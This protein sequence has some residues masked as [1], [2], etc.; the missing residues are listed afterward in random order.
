MEILVSGHTKLFLLNKPIFSNTGKYFFLVAATCNYSNFD[1][2]TDQSSGELLMLM[3]D[4]GAI[5]V[6]SALRA[7]YAD[8]NYA[9]NVD[10]YKY[11]IDT[12]RYGNVKR[13][14]LGDI[15]YKTKQRIHDLINDRKYFLIG[16]PSME[17]QFPKLVAS[18]DS[19]NH[20][21]NTQPIQLQALSQTE[22]V[23]TVRDTGL[24]QPQQISGR[25]NLA[26]YDADRTNT[27][28]APELGSGYKY[29]S[30]GSILFRG[31]D[32]IVNGNMKGEFIV[33]KDI[34]YSIDPGR[35][36]I[37]FTSDSADGA[38]FTRNILMNGT[39]TNAVSDNKG[40]QISLYLDRRSFKPGD[41]VSSSPMLLADFVDSSKYIGRRNWAPS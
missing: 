21:A 20:I 17:L 3:K 7:V 28:N 34:S 11:L 14:R 37:Y 35:I 30:S 32:T 40:P 10:L 23:A 12:T 19:I 4:A 27:I 33:P 39:D 38:G 41:V 16:D 18:V 2:P 25:A 24:N 5:G 6:F 1:L 22:I 15:I 9:L 29:L 26:V 36:V 13:Q 31:Q 8:D